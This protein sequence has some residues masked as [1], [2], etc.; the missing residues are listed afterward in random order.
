MIDYTEIAAYLQQ[1]TDFVQRKIER[2]RLDSEIVLTN[3]DRT[4]TIKFW[5]GSANEVR[6]IYR[7][8]RTAAQ[9]TVAGTSATARTDDRAR[10]MAILANEAATM[11]AASYGT[12]I[13]SQGHYG[14][15][16]KDGTG[17]LKPCDKEAILTA[18]TR[19]FGTRLLPSVIDRELL[20]AWTRAAGGIHIENVK[21]FVFKSE[22]LPGGQ[23]A[24]QR[25]SFDPNEN[26]LC[27]SEFAEIL[28]RTDQARSLVL[29]LG[30]LLDATYSRTQYLHLY[31]QGND[32]KSTL[33]KIIREAF[34]GHGVITA[35]SDDLY[36]AHGTT[37]L[38]GARVLM[39]PEENNSRFMSSSKFKALTGENFTTIN[40]KGAAARTINVF[41]KVI[42]AANNPA[43]L[44]GNV[45]DVRRIVPITLRSILTEDGTAR[46]DEDFVHRI[47][48][49]AGEC[50]QYCYAEFC[51]W[52]RECPNQPIP[53]DR[54][55]IDALK[56]S[57]TQAQAEEFFHENFTLDVDSRV[58]AV[59]IKRIV[60]AQMTDKECRDL[61]TYMRQVGC[62]STKSGSVR[63]WSGLRFTKSAEKVSLN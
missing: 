8:D 22:K 43:E 34:Q 7:R 52:Q 45:A 24:W 62:K 16:L 31:G 47:T 1:P 32:G 54:E 37:R 40:P 33:L 4:R 41:C 26:V 5:R 59:D 21:P 6:E 35:S 63:Y 51:K 48:S 29:W 25:L 17:I 18:F 58:R 15:V 30:S 28:N 27:P 60:K 23:Y 9:P 14:Y 13:D 53:T 42:V 46:H 2:L 36:G 61:Y 12:T 50:L 55:A 11:F 20:K 56:A 57:S 3:Q 19:H 38:E 39:F 10:E 49:K 44:E